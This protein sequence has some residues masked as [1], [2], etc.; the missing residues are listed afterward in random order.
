MITP[1]IEEIKTSLSAFNIFELIKDEPYSFI[2]DSSSTAHDPDLSRYSFLGSKPFTILRSKGS[3]IELIHHDLVEKVRGD[4]FSVLRD[5]LKKYHVTEKNRGIPFQCGAVGYFGYELYAFTEENLPQPAPDDTGIPDCYIGFYD[6]IIAYDHILSKAYVITCGFSH[7]SK[8]KVKRIKRLIALAG[9]AQSIRQTPQ[10]P[11]AKPSACF[12]SNF[13]QDTY[14]KAIE[15]IKEYIARGDVYQ[16]NLSQRFAAEFDSDAFELYRKLRQVNPA[17]FSAFMH[18]DKIKI[19]SSSPERFLKMKDGIIETRPIKGTRP[20]GSSKEEDSLLRNE[21]RQSKKDQAE[22]VM[23]VDLE[24][25]DLGRICKYST[26]SVEKLADLEEYATVFHLVSTISGKV[27]KGKDA[28]DCL[29]ACFPGGSITGAPKI[30]SIQIIR[31]MEPNRRDIYTG[32]IGYI[33]FGGNMDTSIVIRSLL[34]KDT[35]CYLYAGGGIV[36][37]SNPQS[38]YEETF[39]K[40]KAFMK[41]LDTQKVPG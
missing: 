19:L 2:L 17:P 10:S 6:P 4:P 8:T 3:D 26:I 20:R 40:I 31:E 24:R 18:F 39:H 16:V 5:L 15:D 14:I 12:R 41:T 27:A 13:T 28:V 34:I 23:I 7:D 29:K 38:E 33:S 21:L 36:A 22:H 35:N 32:S 9:D 25:N 37:D 1:K 30:R 11:Q